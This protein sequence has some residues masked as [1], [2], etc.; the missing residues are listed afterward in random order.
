MASFI[1]K[2]YTSIKHHARF[3]SYNNKQNHMKAPLPTLSTLALIKH[4]QYNE[5]LT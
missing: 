1:L 3:Q 5:K 4:A 2:S